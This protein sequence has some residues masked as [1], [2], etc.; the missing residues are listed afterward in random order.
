MSVGALDPPVLYT[1]LIEDEVRLRA[2]AVGTVW[3]AL[4]GGTQI[5]VAIRLSVGVWVC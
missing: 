3:D 2:A 5:T 1:G 4:M